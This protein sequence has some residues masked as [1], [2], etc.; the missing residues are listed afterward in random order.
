MDFTRFAA[1]FSGARKAQDSA[2]TAAPAKPGNTKNSH[3]SIAQ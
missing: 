2:K 1:N 3:L